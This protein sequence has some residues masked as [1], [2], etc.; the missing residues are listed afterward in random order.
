MGAIVF[1]CI[2][3]AGKFDVRPRGSIE[4]RRKMFKNKQSY[5]GKMLTVRYQATGDQSQESGIPRFPV[6]IDV[7]DYE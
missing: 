7:R 2:S 6:G 1:E 5:V 4:K 3:E